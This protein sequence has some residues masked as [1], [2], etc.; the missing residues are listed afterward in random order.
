MSYYACYNALYAILIK[1]G[2]K[3]EIHDCSL[4]LMDLLGFDQRETEYMAKLKEDR[5]QA[6]YYLKDIDIKSEEDIKKFILK[7]KEILDAL[8][9]KKIEGIR[10][11]V[12]GFRPG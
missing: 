6:Q 10:E 12:S 11:T 3:C 5:I 8:G 4:E 9:S 1:A 2:I 7:C